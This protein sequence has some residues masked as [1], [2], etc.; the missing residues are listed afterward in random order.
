[1]VPA[2]S[3][4]IS[5]VPHYSG[6]KLK[7]IGF[8]VRDYH[9]LWLAFPDYSVN[10]D[11]SFL[12]DPTTPIEACPIGL[13]WSGFARRYYRNHCIVFFSSRYWDGSLPSV[14]HSCEFTGFPHSDI[15]GS[16]IECISPQLFAAYHVLLR[17]EVPRHSPSAL[18]SLTI[19]LAC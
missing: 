15:C 9:A 10:L 19:K 13:G 8:H 1:M 11:C 6:V 7:I 5:R 14:C 4:R 3:C 12:S 17:L 16:Q 2:N 18:S